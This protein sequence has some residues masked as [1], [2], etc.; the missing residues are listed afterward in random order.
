MSTAD[1]IPAGRM[2]IC[3]LWSV[4]DPKEGRAMFFTIEIAKAG[5]VYK[6]RCPELQVEATGATSEEA[7][8]RL[9]R[10]IDFTVTTA[11]EVPDGPEG[12][13]RRVEEGRWNGEAAPFH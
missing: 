11:A 8:T 5:E 1:F 4:I 12:D 13:V 2:S 10:I 7:V 3:G 9:K 6:V